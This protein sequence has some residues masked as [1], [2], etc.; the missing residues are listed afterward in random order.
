MNSLVAF[1]EESDTDRRG[2]SLS[3]ILQW[4]ADQLESSHNYIQTMF[5]LPEESGVDWNAPTIDREVFNAFRSRPELQ[6]NLRKSFKRILWF[7][8]F[9][10]K[11]E[12]GVKVRLRESSFWLI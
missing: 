5:P 10:L 6:E 11:I 3:D 4:N 7:Y 1:Y 8:G 9:E 2:R 12:G